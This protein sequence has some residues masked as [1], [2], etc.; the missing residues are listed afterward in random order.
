M[1][2]KTTGI[3]VE[4]RLIEPPVLCFEELLSDEGE[5]GGVVEI[6]GKV[7]ITGIWR[8]C[9]VRGISFDEEAIDREV[10]ENCARFFFSRL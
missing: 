3:L 7:K 5:V 1:T 2:Q 9:H 8:R 6:A 4:L 10:A